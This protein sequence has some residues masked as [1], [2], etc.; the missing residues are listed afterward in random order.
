MSAL[1][2]RDVLRPAPTG[3]K[4][5]LMA[6]LM[7]RIPA[8]FTALRAVW[9]I[10]RVGSV[11]AATRYD[12][13]R[14]VFLNDAAFGVPYKPQLDIIMGGQ[15]FFLGMGD[16]PQYRADTSAM[17]RVLLA[18]DIPGRLAPA[19]EA[20][21]ETIVANAGGKLEVV[22]RSCAQRDFRRARRVFRRAQSTERRSTGVGYAFV[23]VPVRRPG[24]RDSG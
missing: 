3:P 1:T 8:L 14:E 23:R 7:E 9:P 16:T 13:V 19:V 18:D 4:R 17:R 10:P 22:D 15:P 24:R 2:S 20:Q 12:D 11:V 21:A 6:W 5:A